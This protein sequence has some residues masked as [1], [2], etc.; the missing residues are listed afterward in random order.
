MLRA[1]A[2]GA[3]AVLLGRPVL[4]GLAVG[5]EAGARE[6]LDTFRAEL[7]RAMAFCGAPTLADVRPNLVLRAEAPVR[8]GNGTLTGASRGQAA[9]GVQTPR[10][11]KSGS[12][13]YANVSPSSIVCGSASTLPPSSFTR[14]HVCATSSTCTQMIAIGAWPSMSGAMPPPIGASSPRSTS[15]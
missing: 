3:T 4:W 5:G 14:A 13:T 7:A 8:G 6:V 9:G 15:E 2:L 11:P 12:A 10:T 1:L